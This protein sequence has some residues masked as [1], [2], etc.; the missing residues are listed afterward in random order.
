MVNSLA[1][2]QPEGTMDSA[3]AWSTRSST[4][5]GSVSAAAR[6]GS[7]QMSLPQQ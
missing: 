3:Q 2:F 7:H 1:K 6:H 5:G 4:T